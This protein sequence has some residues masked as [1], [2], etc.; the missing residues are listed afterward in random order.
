MPILII[1]PNSFSQILDEIM[2]A[3]SAA[4]SV[5]ACREAAIYSNST[6]RRD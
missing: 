3:Y 5:D 6:L 4:Y 2:T 1:D